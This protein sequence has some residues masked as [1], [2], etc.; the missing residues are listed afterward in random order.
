MTRQEL[1]QCDVELIPLVAREGSSPVA[2]EH[3]RSYNENV[4][5]V[6][7]ALLEPAK[8]LLERGALLPQLA[9]CLEKAVAELVFWRRVL[10][11][12]HGE[13]LGPEPGRPDYL[14]HWVM[15]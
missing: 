6:R 2:R 14:V 12:V 13:A 8:D 10:W 4:A 9:A 7:A 5:D 1:Q 15:G 11:D 3:A